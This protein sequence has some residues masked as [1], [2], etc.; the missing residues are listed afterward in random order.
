MPRQP[1]FA[2]LVIDENDRPVQTGFIGEEPAYIINDAGFLRHIP[3]E[4][5]DKQVL[6]YMQEMM[7]GSEDLISEQAAKMMGQDDIFSKA[8]IEQQ[9]KNIDQQFDMLMQQGIPEDGRAYLG[10]L[11]FKIVINYHGEIVKIEQPSTAD[12]EGGDE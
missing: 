8:M 9:L 5:V 11:G 12:D 4:Q 7:K 1:L 2:G 6:K 3:A 10:M